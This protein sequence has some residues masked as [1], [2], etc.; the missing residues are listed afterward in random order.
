M[1]TYRSIMNEV[2]LGYYVVVYTPPV[3]KILRSGT[4]ATEKY[5]KL[6]SYAL[7]FSSNVN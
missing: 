2:L 6:P 1:L 4:N 5:F 3:I 7:F